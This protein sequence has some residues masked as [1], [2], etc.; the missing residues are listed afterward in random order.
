MPPKRKSTNGTRRTSAAAAT[1]S[2]PNVSDDSSE[3]MVFSQVS[4]KSRS[5]VSAKTNDVAKS[6]SNGKNGKGKLTRSS[7]RAS[8]KSDQV[9]IFP[10][11]MFL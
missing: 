8:A 7:T 10:L 6:A 2:P 9:C 1:S 3:E 5:S 11:I 4:V